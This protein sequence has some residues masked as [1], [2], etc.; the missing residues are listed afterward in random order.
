VNSEK[1]VELDFVEEDDVLE[2]D[3][4]REAVDYLLLSDSI[5]R[6][7]GTQCPKDKFPRGEPII[8]TFWLGKIKILKCVVP[9]ADAGRLWIQA[10]AL[11]RDFNVGHVICHVGA[12]YVPTAHRNWLHRWKKSQ[13]HFT[14]PTSAG[15]NIQDLLC[16]LESLFKCDVVFSM[17]LPHLD[18]AFIENINDINAAVIEFCELKGFGVIRF[19][20]FERSPFGRLDSRMY[21]KMDRVHLGPLG[22]ANVWGTVCEHI[23]SEWMVDQDDRLY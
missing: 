8:E 20:T 6:H 5:Y 22:I 7:F 14:D 16:G 13:L 9:G 19:P 12:N 15:K 17:I 3:D 23:I 21:A 2:E 1:E 10:C 11:V 18:Y 4:G